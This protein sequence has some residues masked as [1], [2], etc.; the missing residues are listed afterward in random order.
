[1]SVKKFGEFQPINEDLNEFSTEDLRAELARRDKEEEDT[2]NAQL[3]PITIAILKE[4]DFA[5]REYGAYTFADKGVYEVMNTDQFV[6]P[7]KRMTIP[8]I[9]SILSQCLDNTGDKNGR[10]VQD[11]VDA[12]IG[13]L[14]SLSEEDFSELLSS[15]DRFEY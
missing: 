7:L 4:V 14:D 1:M 9:A 13:E 6:N 8:E 12:I 10:Y 3:H 5:L 2:R 15:D 11:T